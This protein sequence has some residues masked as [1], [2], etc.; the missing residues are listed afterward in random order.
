LSIKYQIVTASRKGFDKKESYPSKELAQAKIEQSY[1]NYSHM[2]ICM[3]DT[4]GIGTQL[5]TSKG[6][7][8]VIV[9]ETDLFWTIDRPV[10]G[11]CDFTKLGVEQNFFNKTFIAKEE[12]NG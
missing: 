2:I 7:Y 9:Y 12:N 1:A 8:G 6:Y 5:Y 4:I 3:P 11:K 10:N